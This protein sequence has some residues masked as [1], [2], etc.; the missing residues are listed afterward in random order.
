MYL[1]INSDYSFYIN[2]YDGA[3][4]LSKFVTDWDNKKK[5]YTQLMPID[6]R[7]PVNGRQSRFNLHVRNTKSKYWTE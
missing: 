7:K 2:T 6:Y 5:R 3:I 4:N 1:K